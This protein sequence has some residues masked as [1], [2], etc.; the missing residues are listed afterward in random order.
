M[1]EERIQEG[2]Q[3]LIIN[4]TDHFRIF[5]N[6]PLQNTQQELEDTIHVLGEGLLDVSAP[7]GGQRLKG[8]HVLRKP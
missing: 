4:Y 7:L 5:L 2:F 6:I 8:D 3:L 1:I